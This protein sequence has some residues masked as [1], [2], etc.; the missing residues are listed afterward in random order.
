MK[1]MHYR[2]EEM[3]SDSYT[4]ALQGEL[5]RFFRS[6]IMGHVSI[7]DMFSDDPKIKERVERWNKFR[8]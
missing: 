4:K 6:I 7:F 5:F 8:I 2:T 3:L 1:V